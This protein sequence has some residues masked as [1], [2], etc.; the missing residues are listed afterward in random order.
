MTEA[1]ELLSAIEM[2]L[3]GA[4][5]R[6]S[7]RA[8]VSFLGAAP[9]EVL[10]F[11]PDRTGVVRYA[12]LGMSATPMIDPSAAVVPAD[13]PREELVLSLRGGRDSVLRR[14][15]AI[16]ASPTVEGLVLQAGAGVDLGEPLWHGARFPAVLVGEPGGLVPDLPRVGGEPVRFFPLLPMTPSEAAWK[17]VHGAAAL[18]RRWLDH[19]ADLRDP[20]RPEVPL[21][22]LP[23]ARG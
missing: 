18:E 3:T 11:G 14:L 23:A 16:A 6:E 19:G 20:E 21:D 2:A 12:T 8:T 7:A 5:G 9:I 13:G 1:A 22:V 15:A 10:R 4:L 17:R